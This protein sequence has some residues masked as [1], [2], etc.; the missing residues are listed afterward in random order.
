MWISVFCSL[1]RAPSTNK[2]IIHIICYSSWFPTG[3]FFSSQHHHSVKIFPSIS[4]AA[5]VIRRG[6]LMKQSSFP[7]TVNGPQDQLL[8]SSTV[9]VTPPSSVLLSLL[10]QMTWFVFFNKPFI[11]HLHNEY[12]NYWPDGLSNNKENGWV[13]GCMLSKSKRITQFDS[14]RK[15]TWH[16]GQNQSKQRSVLNW[17]GTLWKAGLAYEE[18]R[19]RWGLK[20]RK[21]SNRSVYYPQPPFLIQRDASEVQQRFWCSKHFSSSAHLSSCMQ[22]ACDTEQMFASG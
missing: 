10:S 7:P 9:E 22:T 11:V 21:K 15:R 4:A 18:V 17:G 1:W 8:C 19:P 16:A 12:C 20:S 2:A 6:T 3:A 14:P 5:A 13:G